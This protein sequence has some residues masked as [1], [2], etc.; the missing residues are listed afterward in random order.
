M[1]RP[2]S[3]PRI[4]ESHRAAILEFLRFYADEPEEDARFGVWVVDRCN[5]LPLGDLPIPELV[6]DEYM[7]RRT[8]K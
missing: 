6:V 8:G 4:P 2:Q 3:S 7:K 5:A 1:T